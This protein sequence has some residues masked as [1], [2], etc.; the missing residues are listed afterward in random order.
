MQPI[1]FVHKHDPD[2]RL[3]V[4]LPTGQAG[5]DAIA[6][7]GDAIAANNQYHASYELTRVCA[8]EPIGAELAE[9]LRNW[10]GVATAAARAIYDALDFD[11]PK[12]LDP[13]AVA[14]DYET[15]KA[16]PGMPSLMQI[17]QWIRQYPRKGPPGEGQFGIA[18]FDF[19]AV[20][21]RAPE[22]TEWF[23]VE[24]MRKAGK[25]YA[26]MRSFVQSCTL[27]NVADVLERN[28][29]NPL[30]VLVLGRFIRNAAGEDFA[31]RMGE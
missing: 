4:A 9:L 29:A 31:K 21:Y 14:A 6:D 22:P 16:T 25:G 8:V 5:E 17:E 12:L 27:A 18:V 15:H 30:I 13:R 3:T 7:Y 23:A 28:K 20:P 1:H 19:G 11:S 24:S 2:L 26:T 10:S